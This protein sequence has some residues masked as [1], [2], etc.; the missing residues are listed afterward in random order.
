MTRDIPGNWTYCEHSDGFSLK[1][2][3]GWGD[4]LKLLGVILACSPFIWAVLLFIRDTCFGWD[5]NGSLNW[6]AALAI[7]SFFVI[8]VTFALRAALRH[9]GPRELRFTSGILESR[10][11]HL[12]RRKIPLHQLSGIK[13]HTIRGR[14]GLHG[15]DRYLAYLYL[16]RT[17]KR[18]VKIFLFSCDDLSSEIK[19]VWDSLIDRLLAQMAES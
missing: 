15:S 18:P 9:Y 6:S 4:T 3:F 7:S 11:A 13:L 17:K 14:G 12:L 16:N 19:P 5:S 1:N 2:K 8:I 10:L